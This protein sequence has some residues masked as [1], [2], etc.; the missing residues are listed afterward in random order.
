MTPHPIHL[1]S[2]EEMIIQPSGDIAR[3]EARELG[4]GKIGG[5]EVA[6]RRFGKVE[7]LPPYRSTLVRRG[8]KDMEW[9]STGISDGYYQERTIYIVSSLV[10]S[11][12]PNRHDLAAPDTGKTA[13]RNEAGQVTAVKRL[14]MNPC[15][16][17]EDEDCA[18]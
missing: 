16:V 12:C 1:I 6:E 17:L 13:I 3:V 9:I 8:G 10:L 14:I 15:A 7:G 4:L 18:F 5:I 2:D 11:A